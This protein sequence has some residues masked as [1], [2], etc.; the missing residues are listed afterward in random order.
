MA[1]CGQVTEKQ[2]KT[3]NENAIEQDEENLTISERWVGTWERGD[4]GILEIKNIE[5]NSIEFSIDVTSGGHD[6]SL[7]GKAPVTN[8]VAIFTICDCV[9]E[10]TLQGD[11]TIVVTEDNCSSMA[12]M[13][14][15]F[16]GEYKNDRSKAKS[17][18]LV[19][20][21]V[22]KNNDEDAAFRAVVRDKYKLFVE[23]TQISFAK[24]DIDDFN[25][26]VET[27]AVRGLYNISENIIM[28]DA[29]LNIWAAVLSNSKVYYFTNDNEYKNKL[30]K[31]IE[32]WRN[33]FAGKKV[34]Y[35][36]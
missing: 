32:K 2:T 14:A 35:N 1:S 30:P 11:S 6:G 36:E 13:G 19:D 27:S 28:I 18:T 23:S 25:A 3:N 21:G 5:G 29:S 22:L 4:N 17:E 16:F 20:L 8:N 34:I 10:L 26:R 33:S 9:L 31:T 24:D 7:A 12:G 15:Y